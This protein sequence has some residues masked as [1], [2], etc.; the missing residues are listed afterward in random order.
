MS[1]KEFRRLRAYEIASKYA[2]RR[3]GHT[4]SRRQTKSVGNAT[5]QKFLKTGG[6]VSELSR[7]QLWG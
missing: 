3:I 1:N 2:P 5:G 4:P 6:I 7:R